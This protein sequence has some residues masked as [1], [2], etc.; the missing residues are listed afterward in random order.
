MRLLY[1]TTFV[2]ALAISFFAQKPDEILATANGLNF[3]I[4]SL[5]AEGRRLF[6]NPQKRVA[7]VRSWFVSEMITDILLETEARATKTPI[8]KLL[9]IEFKKIPT[10][11]DAEIKAVFDA[12]AAVLADKSPAGA[13][14]EIISYLRGQSEHKATLN[15]IDRLKVKHR[16]TVGKDVNAPALKP[17]DSLF[18]IAGKKVFVQEFESAHRAALR[19]LPL[20]IYD[21]IK[22]DLESSIFSTLVNEEA[23]ARSTDAAGVIGAEITD[24]MRDFSDD[25]RA[26]LESAL[27]K[28]LFTKFNVKILLKEPEPFVQNISVDD[29]PVQGK[30][31]A[32][33]TV[34]MFSDFQC[35][36]CAA[37][38]PRLKKVL[39]EY[40]DKVR[41]AVRDNPL[42]RLHPNAFQAALAANAANRQG[43]FFEYIE[44]LY[45]N[46]SALDPA[47]LK[48]YAA[49]LGLNVALF[50]ID[51]SN[52]KAAAEVRKDIADGIRYGVS[53]TPTVFVNG[54]KVRR[55]S[56]EGFRNAIDRVLK[57]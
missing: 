35:P 19:L 18:S 2:F 5:S 36:A 21:D 53:G 54:V 26:D 13:R 40:G 50:E 10:P 1:S 34:V 45:N 57:K 15:F 3:T 6:D 12:N 39:A 17:V 38:H 55:L 48:K 52:E 24:K 33:V 32:P 46:Q 31:N 4:A 51:L 11:T 27:Q 9:E 14:S 37:A 41:F 56:A 23:K 16:F 49:D 47:S 25:E 43:K 7:D 42:E 8:K 30:A 28:N 44:V 22:S 20:D 29:D